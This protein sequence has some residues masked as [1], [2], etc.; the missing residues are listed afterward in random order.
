LAARSSKKK[1]KKKMRIKS[2]EKEPFPKKFASTV[3]AS[4]PIDID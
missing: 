2:F 1:D 4:A 3:T